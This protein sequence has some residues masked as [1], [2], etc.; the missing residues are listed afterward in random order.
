MIPVTI[1][2]VP[3]TPKFIGTLDPNFKDWWYSNILP[4]D[5]DEIIDSTW[6]YGQYHVCFAKMNDGT[7]S[8]YQSRDNGVNWS[9]V[10]NIAGI[11]YKIVRID[12][13]MVLASTS[14]G[15]YRSNNSGTSWVLVSSDALGCHG[16]VEFSKDRIAAID[17]TK[18]WI[19]SDNGNTWLNV[20]AFEKCFFVSGM[21]GVLYLIVNITISG[22]GTRPWI[23]SSDDGGLSF[24]GTV[25]DV[26]NNGINSLGPV[27][28]L[29]CTG[30]VNGIPTFIIQQH[31]AVYSKS[32]NKAYP[33]LRH[34]YNTWDATRGG[35]SCS[36]R[37]DAPY[38]PICDLSSKEV[39]LTGTS[40]FSKYCI[41]VGRDVNNVPIMK[42]STDG[43]ITWNDINISDITIYDG[44]D[45]AQEMLSSGGSFL[46]D[47]YISLV[48]TGPP[49]HNSGNWSMSKLVMEM[50]ISFD[51][52]Y[53]TSIN[54]NNRIGFDLISILNREKS[55]EMDFITNLHMTNSYTFGLL[56]EKSHQKVNEIK[57][58]IMK[59]IEKTPTM[60]MILAFLN[61][62][63]IPMDQLTLKTCTKGLIMDILNENTNSTSLSMDVSIQDVITYDILNN[64]ERYNPQFPA[65]GYGY[66]KRSYPIFDSRY[67]TKT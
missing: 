23:L 33:M 44:P 40:T 5:I 46:E 6:V 1:T 10:K 47:Q 52:D 32:K 61:T 3:N 25:K 59:K 15:W 39:L 48:W 57:A 54:R 41:Y 21:N 38:T 55:Y 28:N 11:I 18:L 31:I 36:A 63:D 20:F 60:D 37:F 16:V 43:G 22:F 8:I 35:Y 12:Y 14:V 19:S 53:K 64:S 67:E 42:D 29:I 49:C 24:G 26:F 56:V 65:I 17:N 4:G 9:I 7:Y 62:K 58:Y 30:S 27:T 66:K 2:K 50:G 13:G 51:V 34:Y 45:L